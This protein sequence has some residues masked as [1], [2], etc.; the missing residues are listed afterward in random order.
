MAQLEF[1]NSN[2]FS[3]ANLVSYYKLENVNDSKGSNTLTNNGS[4]TFTSAR[5][6]NGANFGSA[7]SSKYLSGAYTYVASTTDNTVALWLKPGADENQFLSFSSDGGRE[8]YFGHNPTGY[9]NLHQCASDASEVDFPNYQIPSWDNSV[10]GHYAFTCKTSGSDT[11]LSI[12]WNG[13]LVGQNTRTGKLPGKL[14]TLN[15]ARL[16][17]ET[18]FLGNGLYDDLAI[19]SRAL[20]DSEMANLYAVTDYSYNRSIDDY[21]LWT[22]GVQIGS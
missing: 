10:W 12:Y 14:G 5:W 13:Q 15:I 4:T 19:F 1:V 6:N 11:I 2:F 9:I 7:N 8:Y 16:V 22:P 20:S 3:D 21:S 17:L 18:S